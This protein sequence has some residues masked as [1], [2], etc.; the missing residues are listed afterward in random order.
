MRPKLFKKLL[1]SKG[2][3]KQKEKTYRTGENKCKL[4]DQQGVCKIYKLL[5]QL[6]QKQKSNH[7]MIRRPE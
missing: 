6:N 7:K 5:I 3:H 2:N 1:H 4:C